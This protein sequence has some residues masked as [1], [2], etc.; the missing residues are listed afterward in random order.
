M[1]VYRI[2][3]IDANELHESKSRGEERERKRKRQRQRQRCVCVRQNSLY[4]DYIFWLDIRPVTR[5]F[6]QATGHSARQ[7]TD[8]L[9]KQ[10][11]DK[12]MH[13][14]RLAI[15]YQTDSQPSVAVKTGKAAAS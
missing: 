6:M 3:A 15:I 14:S 2:D 5:S 8:Q 12:W 1:I 10:M 11:M 9:T 4:G 13:T 7:P